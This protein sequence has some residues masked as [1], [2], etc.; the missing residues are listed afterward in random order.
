MLLLTAQRTMAVPVGRGMFTF[1]TVSP[2]PTETLPIPALVF[3]GRL[4]DTNAV[5]GLDMST[6]ANDMTHW[7]EFHNGVAAGLRIKSDQAKLTSTWIVY[8]RCV[9]YRGV[10]RHNSRLQRPEELSHSHGGLLM[11][12]GLRGHLSNLNSSHIYSYLSQGS[13]GEVIGL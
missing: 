9:L 12:L 10:Q 13:V 8:N 6:V 2:I 4:P 11:A 5:V 3:S 1:D 7:P